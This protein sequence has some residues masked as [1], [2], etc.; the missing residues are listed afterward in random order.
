MTRHLTSRSTG[1]PKLR[2]PGE[3]RVR[4]RKSNMKRAILFLSI[5]A[6]LALSCAMQ[7]RVKVMRYTAEI[8]PPTTQIEVLH[9]KPVTRDYMEIGEIAIR[10]TKATEEN[11][12]VYL[13]GKAKEL[14][15]DAIMIIGERSKG[16]VAM[17]IGTMAVAVPIRELYAI[18]IKYK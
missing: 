9:T 6:V 16:A 1:S 3:L 2:A 13:I 8:F 18:A 5:I 11:A 12:V 10:L 14:G 4:R 15:A 7:P 17:P